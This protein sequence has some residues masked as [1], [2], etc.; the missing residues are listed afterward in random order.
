MRG[1]CGKA[2]TLVVC[3]GHAR[4]AHIAELARADDRVAGKRRVRQGEHHAGVRRARARRSSHA[5]HVRGRL[6][7][8]PRAR[9]ERRSDHA[10]HADTA[11]SY[12]SFEPV[13]HG[14][15]DTEKG[16]AG[17][18]KGSSS[19]AFFAACLYL[20]WYF[21]LSRYSYEVRKS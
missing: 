7:E 12:D 18:M 8:Q 19:L 15:D 2:V 13:V 11:G 3:D 9:R 5:L 20:L 4:A 17:P 6:G 10:E 16:P 1:A 14:L 21:R